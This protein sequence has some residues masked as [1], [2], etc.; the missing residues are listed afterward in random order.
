M[1]QQ[2][3]S[4][5]RRLALSST[6]PSVD[7]LRQV[8]SGRIDR[9]LRS[10]DSVLAL[11]TRPEA[12]YLERRAAAVQARGLIPMDWAPRLWRLIGELRGF[13]QSWAMKPHPLSAAP[14]PWAPRDTAT[15]LVLGT[16]WT[17]PRAPPD[18]PLTPDERERAPW[19]WQVEQA[20]WDLLATILPSTFQPL[21]RDRAD[22]YLA[23]V[24]TMP[25][26][27]SQEAQL[28]AEAAG[29]SSHYKTPAVMGALRN[30]A[31]RGALAPADVRVSGSFADATR[32]WDD[33]RAWGIGAAGLLDILRRATG[34]ARES[35]VYWIRSLREGFGPTVVRRPLPAAVV[36]AASGLALDPA[37]GDE[38]KRLYVY[39]FSVVEALDQRPF[40]PERGLDPGSPRVAELLAAF[41]RWF[42]AHRAGLD[43]LARAQQPSLREAERVMATS[44]CRG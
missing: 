42:A 6:V 16:P 39:G 9:A 8:H 19:P 25:C 40:E 11:V 35:G 27:T 13:D 32:L 4:A 34:P 7:Q 28:F 44:K 29:A 21:E 14:F 3:D 15:R 5:R 37:S 33:P 43:S 23:Q 18:Y 2:P 12:F 17:P 36:L 41:G 30:I 20:L 1:A 26:G 38:W 10:P 31:V 24:M 22:A